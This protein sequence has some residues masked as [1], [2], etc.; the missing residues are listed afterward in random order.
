MIALTDSGLAR[1]TE[2]APVHLLV[3]ELF[4]SQLDDLIDRGGKARM[5]ARPGRS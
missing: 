5:A 2:V 4:V 1:L 3:F